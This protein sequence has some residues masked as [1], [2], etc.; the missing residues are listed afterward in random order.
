GL[1]AGL[2]LCFSRAEA[3]IRGATV[4]GV[5]TCALPISLQL[6]PCP[7]AAKPVGLVVFRSPAGDLG[8]V[9]HAVSAEPQATHIMAQSRRERMRS[10]E[11]RVGKA[12]RPATRNEARRQ[13]EEGRNGQ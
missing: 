4:T 8:F 5:Q 11:R 1:R 13:T 6:T 12:S 3:G 9:R 2:V 7:R 10:E